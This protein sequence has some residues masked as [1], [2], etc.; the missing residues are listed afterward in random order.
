MNKELSDWLQNIANLLAIIVAIVPTWN[1]LK[2]FYFRVCKKEKFKT[3]HSTSNTIENYDDHSFNQVINIENNTFGYP[4]YS[5]INASMDEIEY[6]NYKQKSLWIWNS[7][8]TIMIIIFLSFFIPNFISNIKTFDLNDLPLFTTNLYFTFQNASQNTF[9]TLFFAQIFFSVLVV[10]KMV[11]NP[12]VL[13]R[14]INIFV[15]TLSAIAVIYLYFSFARI[16]IEPLSLNNL[17]YTQNYSWQ[18]SIKSLLN[19]YAV[20]VMFLQ[21][22]YPTLIIDNAIKTLWIGEVH[23]KLLKKQN[24]IYFGKLFQIISP[25]LLLIFWYIIKKFAL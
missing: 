12:N 8:V 3:N 23:F 22:F 10:I 7:V 21:I 5:L 24:R 25:I 19:T 17:V 11:L 4:K 9:N 14:K 2:T 13:Y 20:L 6:E 18:S 1:L 15:Y 16:N